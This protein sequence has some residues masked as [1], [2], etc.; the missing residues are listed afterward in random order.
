MNKIIAILKPIAQKVLA[1]APFPAGLVIGY[2]LHG[3]VKM[4]IDLVIHL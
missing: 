1:V 4:L 2:L 3:P